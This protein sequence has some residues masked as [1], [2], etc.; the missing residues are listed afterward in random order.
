VTGREEEDELFLREL[1]AATA[2]VTFV[3]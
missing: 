1:A 3:K 2:R